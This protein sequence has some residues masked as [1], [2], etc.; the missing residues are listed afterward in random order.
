MTMP[1]QPKIDVEDGIF[2]DHARHIIREQAVGRGC[3]QASDSSRRVIVADSPGSTDGTLVS[4][5]HVLDRLLDIT[6]AAS[7][8]VIRQ[9]VRAV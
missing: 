3:N 5:Q 7:M 6:H 2:L 4:N 8:P 1:P 9:R